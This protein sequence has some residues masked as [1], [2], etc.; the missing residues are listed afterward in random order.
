MEIKA[1]LRRQTFQLTA[2]GD[3]FTR[4]LRSR[5]L[6][7]YVTAASS[8]Y[9]CQFDYIFS[10]SWPFRVLSELRISDK[11]GL[12]LSAVTNLASGRIGMHIISTIPR[13]AIGMQLVRLLRS[14]L[15]QQGC[16]PWP[17]WDKAQSHFGR[18]PP[19]RL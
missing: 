12:E 16:G 6:F 2:A 11:Q 3:S 8:S 9:D 19:L 17:N 18:I 1:A 15:S 5:S 10:A 13:A 14:R 4:E 7:V